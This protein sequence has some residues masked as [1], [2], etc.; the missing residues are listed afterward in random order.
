MEPFGQYRRIGITD[1]MLNC[2]QHGQIAEWLRNSGPIGDLV[3]NLDST[4]HVALLGFHVSFPKGRQQ[5]IATICGI[6]QL[7]QLSE[8]GVDIARFYL[9]HRFCVG[10]RRVELLAP[11]PL[12]PALVTCNRKNQR[13]GSTDNPWTVLLPQS[14]VV[15][16]ADFLIDLA[17]DVAHDAG[18]RLSATDTLTRKPNL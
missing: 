11:L 14:C 9:R 6:R 8:S 16:L 10:V 4:L 15:L 7:R 13:N 1:L 18:L 3:P 17:E 2:E 12:F 5:A